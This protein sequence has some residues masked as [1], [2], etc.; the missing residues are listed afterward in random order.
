LPFANIIEN[1]LGSRYVM[2]KMHY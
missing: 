1:E 2:C